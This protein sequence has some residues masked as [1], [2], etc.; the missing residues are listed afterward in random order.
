LFERKGMALIEFP[1]GKEG[2]YTMPDNVTSIKQYS[3]EGAQK[4]TSVYIP[5]SVTSIG[6]SP[7]YECTSLCSI[8]VSANNKNFRSIDGVLF[9]KK[10]T[11]LMQYP[12][13][14]NETFIIPDGIKTLKSYSFGECHDLKNVTISSSVTTIQTGV[15][16]GCTQL[17][18]ITIPSSVTSMSVAPFLGCDNLASIFVDGNNTSFKD[19]DGVLFN[20]NATTLIQYPCGHAS[21]YTIPDGVT[22]IGQRAFASCNG[23][24]SVTI[25]KSVTSFEERAFNTQMAYVNYLGESEPSCIEQSSTATVATTFA[26]MDFAC[27]P[28]NYSSKSFCGKYF[29]RVSSCEEFAAQDNQC[30]VVVEWQSEEISVKKRAN[31]SLWEKKTNNCFE[32]QCVNSSGGIA[33]SK[34]NST[35][36]IHRMCIDN[37]CVTETDSLNKDKWGVELRVNVTASEF[38]L[39]EFT[40]LLENIT[41]KHDLTVGTEA[42]ETTGCVVRIVV[43]VDDEDDASTI[44]NAIDHKGEGEECTLGIICEAT[45]A[46]LLDKEVEYLILSE[47]YI[48]HIDLLTSLFALMLTI[49]M[50]FI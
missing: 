39:E 26:L 25:P 40:L 33:W 24:S 44:L 1:C 35:N 31:A 5:S 50:M 10:G 20:Y 19:I 9:N 48:M 37:E 21:T 7:F 12:C 8:N 4:L 3:F 15:F 38:D 41:G 22:T 14:K 32:Y 16:Q 43:F 11:T 17:T 34:C 45:S 2:D 46:K 27:V 23:I 30:Y 18:S 49:F 47:S 13:K 42:T 28:L 36:D 29:V 6:N